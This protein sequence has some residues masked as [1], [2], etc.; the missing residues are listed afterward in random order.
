MSLLDAV[1]QLS[2]YLNQSIKAGNS[3]FQS[4]SNASKAQ[5][6]G[7]LT[8]QLQNQTS[9]A[10]LDSIKSNPIADTAIDTVNATA[11]G[12]AQNL[13]STAISKV[14]FNPI[15]NATQ[16]FFTLF[17]TATSLGTE[18]AMALAR[19]TGN[20]LVQALAAKDATSTALDK[21]IVALY[22]ACAVLLGGQ[23]FYNQFLQNLLAAYN[24][25]V[26]ADVNL[27]NVV[28][29]LQSPSN[30]IYK[31]NTFNLAITELTQAQTLILPPPTA[32]VS[33]IRGATDFVSS[34]FTSALKTAENVYAAALSIPG[35]TLQIGKL[36]LQ[37][38]MQ[39]IQVNAYINTYI[40]ALSD[41]ISNYKQSAS[42][43]QATIDHINS[44]TSQL[45]T[46]IAQMN[47][48]LSQNTNNPL[49]VTYKAKLS[50]YGIQWGVTI[51]AIIA[52]LKANPGAGS[53]LLTQTSLSVQA[54]NKSVAQITA[55]SDKNFAGGTVFI[56]AGEEDGFKG[57]VQPVT[58]LLF[59]ANTLVATSTSR[60]DVRSQCQ[61]VRSYVTNSK[62]VD[63]QIVSYL[64][65]FLS[66]TT[67]LTGP[68][69]AAVQKLIAFS[70]KA[71]L[72]R[73]AGLLTNGKVADLFSATPDSS[74]YAGAAVV[75]INS[76]LTTL[77]ALPD[78]TTQQISSMQTLR[79]QVQRE[80]IA[81]SQY[82]GRTAQ[83]TQG[84]DT[85]QEQAKVANDKTL[86][87]TATATAKQLDA[88]VSGANDPA[89][90]TEQAL[91][92]Q[93]TPGGLPSASDVKA[94][95]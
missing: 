93:V 60:N 39:V 67:T 22:N 19:N 90:Q 29:A 61:V 26:Q 58:R 73:L 81:Q 79:D 2:D 17:A 16:Q 35:I 18:V 76:I 78:A 49:D 77:S 38:E 88:S 7:Q 72:D 59:T 36:V 43:N 85:A 10:T 25:L 11:T 56:D 68:A 28:L 70:N 87:T 41:Y 23:P 62:L 46:L 5:P 14:N 4:T 6:D 65:P 40:N 86:V 54:Y 71:G 33:S 83:S 13:V 45:D 31:T 95:L 21:E 3:S 1:N 20:N 57:L 55:I 8:A 30:P 47:T 66:T 48:I 15:Q 44:G 52:W 37:Y 82:A 50:S 24:L 92:P 94:T 64:Q 32:N 34:S 80:Q 84:A 69:N 51:A 27:K 74:T 91:T 42:V 12:L 63:A 89:T 9:T 53:A 75:G